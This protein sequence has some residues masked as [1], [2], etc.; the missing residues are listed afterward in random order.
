VEA[1]NRPALE[2]LNSRLPA[3]TQLTFTSGGGS[4]IPLYSGLSEAQLAVC[5]AVLPALSDPAL[6]A[7]AKAQQLKQEALIA[8]LLTLVSRCLAWLPPAPGPRR[9]PR[10]QRPRRRAGSR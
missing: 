10:M 2:L 4:S 8:R 5:R 6:V 9:F 3:A 1:V 7:L